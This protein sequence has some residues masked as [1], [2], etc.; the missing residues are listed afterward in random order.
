MNKQAAKRVILAQIASDGGKGITDLLDVIPASLKPSASKAWQK[1]YLVKDILIQQACEIVCRS[2]DKDIRFF[3]VEDKDH[4]A[5]YI[6][7]FDVVIDNKRHQVSFHSFWDGWCR[8]LRGSTRSMGRWDHLSSRA[9]CEK[10]VYR[11]F[12]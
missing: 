1:G 3:V 10:L 6:I 4:V 11:F 9:T 7:Y 5:D 8:Y 12:A 2:H